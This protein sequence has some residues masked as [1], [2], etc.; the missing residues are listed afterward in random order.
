MR[1]TEDVLKSLRGIYCRT[2]ALLMFMRSIYWFLPMPS[3]FKPGKCITCGVR[4]V[5][6]A[7]AVRV[8]VRCVYAVCEA[9]V[10][11]VVRMGR[12]QCIVC[13]MYV[14]C[15]HVC[16]ARVSAPKKMVPVH[17]SDEA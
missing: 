4:C 8:R 10:A 3:E 15:V 16:G 2:L 9:C 13:G 12:A 5:C 7:C 11:G 17:V 6:G 14:V 1:A